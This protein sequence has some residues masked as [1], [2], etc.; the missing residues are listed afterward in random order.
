MNIS[1]MVTTLAQNHP[2]KK[3]K[4]DFAK[5]IVKNIFKQSSKTLFT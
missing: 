3:K 5:C 4:I 2:S 1:C